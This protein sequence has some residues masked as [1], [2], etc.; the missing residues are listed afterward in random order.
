MKR[1]KLV[2]YSSI[3][4]MF[5]YLTTRNYNMYRVGLFLLSFRHKKET[6][7]IFFFRLE[8]FKHSQKLTE[9]D[10]FFFG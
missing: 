3:L 9:I 1:P 4:S 6:I 10:F 5:Q 8:H 7:R 2:V